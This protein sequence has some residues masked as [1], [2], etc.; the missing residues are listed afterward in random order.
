[1]SQWDT[2]PCSVRDC[3]KA[4]ECQGSGI[5]GMDGNT[6]AI[7][8]GMPAF[9]AAEMKTA[10]DYVRGRK[11]NEGIGLEMGGMKFTFLR[12]LEDTETYVFK[13]KAKRDENGDEIEALDDRDK[14]QLYLQLAKTVVMIALFKG[15]AKGN[16]V[17]GVARMNS[18]VDYLKGQNM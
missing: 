5:Y 12:S 10:I 15:G 7:T 16:D 4:G 14:Y 11:Y 17:E 6:Y 9:P 2:Y 13:R 1:M 18:L 3:S 8:D